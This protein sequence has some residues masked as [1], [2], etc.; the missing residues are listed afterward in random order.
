MQLRYRSYKSVLFPD[1]VFSKGTPCPIP[2]ESVEI[3]ANKGYIVYMKGLLIA[4][5]ITV[6]GTFASAQFQSDLRML[7]GQREVTIPFDYE[8]NFIVIR[9]L[10]NNMIPLRFIL[11]TGAENTV[12]TQRAF[13]DLMQVNYRRRFSLVGSDLNTELYA[14]LAT[15][16]SLRLGQYL[17]ATNR[18]IL[19]LEEDYF[20]FEEYAGIDVQGI[21]GA[22]FLR[23]FIVHIDFRKN[24]LT[25]TD[26]SVFEPPTKGYMAFDLE[27]FRFRPYI[28][29]PIEQQGWK[30]TEL[31]LLLDTGAGLPLM[32]HTNT[33]SSLRL[34]DETIITNIG[35]GLGGYIEGFVGRME[36]VHMGAFPLSDVITYYHDLH[37]DF[38]TLLI[39]GRNGIL[40]NLILDRFDVIIDYVKGRLYIKPVKRWRRRFRYDRS[41]LT[42]AAGGSTMNTFQVLGVL[43]D[44]PAEEAGIQPGDRIMAINGISSKLLTLSGMNVRLRK[45]VGKRIKLR[46]KRG[47]E[48]LKVKFRL[49]DLI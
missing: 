22:D 11:D 17:L 47:E 4:L 21:L 16:I 39:N 19:V 42:L 34:P 31:K 26:P 23:R 35:M 13:A 7:Q 14:Y 37:P 18:N 2:S 33:D 5:F 48:V 32:V 29:V 24:R 10:F 41:G 49:R 40:G 15:G 9:V 28:N 6:F 36:K 46:I 3:L 25:L 44:S 38:D 45:R 8:N 43:P 1:R 20:R 12:L 27:F 30:P